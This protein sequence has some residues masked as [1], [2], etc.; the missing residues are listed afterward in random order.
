MLKKK[1]KKNRNK[2]GKIYLNDK[3]FTNHQEMRI[4]DRIKNID[5]HLNQIKNIQVSNFLIRIIRLKH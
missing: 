5:E 4:N 2:I 1:I 3:K